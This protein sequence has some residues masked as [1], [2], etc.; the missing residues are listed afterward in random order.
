VEWLKIEEW[1]IVDVSVPLEEP[2]AGTPVVR[3]AIIRGNYTAL[4]TNVLKS[5]K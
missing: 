2:L 1:A 5:I 4:S 3:V